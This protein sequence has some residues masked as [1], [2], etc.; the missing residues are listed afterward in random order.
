[1]FRPHHVSLPVVLCALLAAPAQAAISRTYVAS[2]GNDANTAY[3]CDFAHPCRTF[4]TAF[5]QTTSGGEILAV[6]GSGYGTIAIDRS[7]SII[8]NPGAFAGIGVFS[9]AGV[10]IAAAGVNVVLRGLTINGQGGT[11]GVSMGNGASLSIEDCVIA[12]FSSGNYGVYVNGPVS[13]RMVNTLV[14]DS[15]WAVYLAGGATASISSSKFLGNYV[16]IIGY[17]TTATTTSIAITDAVVSGGSYGIVSQTGFAGAITRVTV[18][19]S[20]ITRNSVIGLSQYAPSG[21]A[22]L[23]SLGNNAVRQNNVNTDGTI[24]TVAPL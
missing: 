9:G 8:A 18:G 10:S 7:V 19:D 2:Y 6:D 12:N 1:M 14:R 22:T 3:S 21:T 24:T 4:Q 23:E 5:S 16:G 20:T 13:V 11:Y 15:Y 17:T